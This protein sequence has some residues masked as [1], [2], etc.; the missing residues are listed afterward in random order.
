MIQQIFI[1][2]VPGGI[3]ALAVIAPRV[4]PPHDDQGVNSLRWNR[5]GNKLVDQVSG[6]DYRFCPLKDGWRGNEAR[7]G[8]RCAQGMWQ[9]ED[10]GSNPGTVSRNSS[11]TNPPGNPT[12]YPCSTARQYLVLVFTSHTHIYYH[13]DSWPQN[14]FDSYLMGL[15]SKKKKNTKISQTLSRRT[16][17]FGEHLVS[18]VFWDI[19]LEISLD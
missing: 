12:S 3:G 13:T 1:T 6:K 2:L 9:L 16:P 19:F 18:L 8:G 17:V 11:P 5:T 10:E 7:A 14:L 4:F 15:E